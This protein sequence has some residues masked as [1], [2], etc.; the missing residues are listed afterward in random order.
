[1]RAS[2]HGPRSHQQSPGRLAAGD[3]L[4][5]E[6]QRTRTDAAWRCIGAP[7]RLAHALRQA[8][9]MSHAGANRNRLRP[10][11]VTWTA[12]WLS[13]GRCCVV[14]GSYMASILVAPVQTHRRCTTAVTVTDYKHP[15]HMSC[16][17]SRP[18]MHGGVPRCSL[19]WPPAHVRSAAPPRASPVSGHPRFAPS[20]PAPR[21]AA[22]P[23]QHGVQVAHA[24]DARAAA[25]A[26]GDRI[27]LQQLAQH[28]AA[29][30]GNVVQRAPPACSKSGAD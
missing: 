14:N 21:G 24:A 28:Y 23:M 18:C 15:G 7:A 13:I 6:L 25:H 30:A 26:L 9:V 2:R 16:C 3:A 1:M 11:A 19:C 20:A 10:I 27:A 4:K 5:R 8:D 29:S 17:V 12:N 22:R